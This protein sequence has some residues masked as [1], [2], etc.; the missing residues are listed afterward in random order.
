[1]QLGTTWTRKNYVNPRA[2][3]PVTLTVVQR[4]PR[5]VTFSNSGWLE[6]PHRIGFT[7]EQKDG[8][9][10]I[11]DKSGRPMVSYAPVA[12]A[13]V[14]GGAKARSL[15]EDMLPPTGGFTGPDDEPESPA[16]EG[17]AKQVALG[18]I[19]AVLP[20]DAQESI[21]SLLHSTTSDLDLANEA[22]A[23]LTPHRVALEAFGVV[24]E[25]LAYMLV[26]VRQQAAGS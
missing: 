2:S 16:D 3:E 12:V 6:W 4:S 11:S 22:K 7:V 8:G 1:M 13:E 20:A 25:W 24:P 21:I 19:L 10:L 26:V 9:W 17:G 18:D 14:A 15:L 5:D 23:I